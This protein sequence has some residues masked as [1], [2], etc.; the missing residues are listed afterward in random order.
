MKFGTDG[1]HNERPRSALCLD[2]WRGYVCMP[3][4]IMYFAVV[5]GVFE[6]GL[7]GSFV[8]HKSRGKGAIPIYIYTYTYINIY[9]LL[10]IC[11]LARLRPGLS[12]SQEAT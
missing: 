3:I 10:Y 4:Q 5:H 11:W 9:R 12:S 2:A 1:V 7:T 6:A 8:V